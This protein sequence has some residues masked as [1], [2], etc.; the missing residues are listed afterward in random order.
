MS[1]ISSKLYA[2]QSWELSP[3]L[4]MEW[5]GNE[6]KEV[7]ERRC[8][9]G[10]GEYV[11]GE[12]FGAEKGLKNPWAEEQ[13]V[14]LVH[15]QNGLNGLILNWWLL[16]HSSPGSIVDRSKDQLSDSYSTLAFCS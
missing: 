12:N 9:G 8:G 4:E 11:G 10:G 6:V 13:D 3:A 14:F 15:P 5:A 16:V 7:G 2:I 1:H